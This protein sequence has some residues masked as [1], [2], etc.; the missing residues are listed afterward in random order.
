MAEGCPGHRCRRALVAAVIAASAVSLGVFVAPG[1]ASAVT[2]SPASLVFPDTPVGASSVLRV[3]IN[4]PASDGNQTIQIASTAPSDSANFRY[5]PGCS[6]QVA[7][8]PGNSC[9][10]D[11]E[12]TP[13]TAGLHAT[14]AVIMVNDQQHTIR[15]SGTAVAPPTTPPPTTPPPTTEA[16]TTT[17]ATTPAE[18]TTTAPPTTGPTTT[19]T[20]AGTTTL[21]VAPP[22]SAPGT[23]PAATQSATTTPAPPPPPFVATG[24]SPGPLAPGGHAQIIADGLVAFPA[25][26]FRWDYTLLEPG[27]WPFTFENSPPTL[28]ANDGPDAVL[29]GVPDPLAL[30]DAGGAVFVPAASS[31]AIS[32]LVE[33]AVATGR[34]ITFVESADAVA[35]SPGEGVR[36]VNLIRDVLAPREAL[37]VTS[38]FPVLVVV[39]AGTVVDAPAGT[40]LPAGTAQALGPTAQLV[41]GSTEPATVLVAAIGNLIP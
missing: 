40:V 39:V 33:G 5:S 15:L 36:D 10:F 3:V 29:A 35:F 24:L 8:A 23:V 30:V 38:A 7:F 21:F 14:R 1:A 25:G 28:I 9:P 17:E 37:T 34:R 11:Y 32:P 19:G 20:V 27:A 18:P 16:P 26:G 6:G 12:F 4:N 22:N 41:N 2:V 31:G 13:Q